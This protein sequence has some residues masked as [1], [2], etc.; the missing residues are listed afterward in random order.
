MNFNIPQRGG[1]STNFFNMDFNCRLKFFLGFSLFYL[2]FLSCNQEDFSPKPKGYFRIELPARSFQKYSGN[3]PF[4]FE[5]HRDAVIGN[6]NE[7][8]SEPCWMNID[9]PFL[10]ATIHLSYKKIEKKSPGISTFESDS[11]MNREENLLNDFIEDSRT[12]VY[13]HSVKASNIIED[14]IIDD[15]SKVYGL[16][17]TLEGNAASSMQ[18]YLTDS[19]NHFVRGALYF[20]TET[21]ADS[22]APV[23]RY[24]QEDI[25][26]FVNTFEWK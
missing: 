12:L 10:N 9:Y 22:L 16:I 26:H 2:I 24:V 7:K 21:N 4:T 18:F 13:K 11:L 25:L 19:V 3:C 6:D 15:S 8:I 20:N 23:I 17:Y 1:I 14:R 5:F